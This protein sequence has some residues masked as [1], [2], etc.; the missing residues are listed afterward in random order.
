[1]KELAVI[2]VSCALAGCAL[3]SEPWPAAGTG[4]FAEWTPINDVRLQALDDR[5]EAARA[6][7]AETYAAGA[8]GAYADAMLLFTR[9]RR[10]LAAGL[11]ADGN[12]DLARLEQQVAAIEA[13]LSPKGMANHRRLS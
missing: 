6:R 4:G 12:A 10:E 7:G 8:Y 13:T 3:K 5:L 9:C 1:L 2:V 11:T